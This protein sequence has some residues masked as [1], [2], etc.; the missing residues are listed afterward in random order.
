MAT[1]RHILTASI[2]AVVLSARVAHADVGFDMSGGPSVRWIRTMPT[3]S[4]SGVT[5]AAREVPEQQVAMG[6]SL[7]ALGGAFDM[8]FV[9]DDRWVVPGFGFG[10]YGAVGS[11]SAIV[12]SVDGSIARVRP[13]S[14]YAVELLLPGVGYRVKRRR[15]MFSASLR[16]GVSGVKVRG[17][18]AGGADEQPL[19]L[20]AWSPM[21]QAELEVCRR[22]DPSTRACLQVA[23]R[24]Y[25]FS[26]MNGAT[27]GL[28]IE[29]GK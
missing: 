27:F 10:A 15:F 9:V 18:V 4:S 7:V 26:I 5:T 28:R 6:D 19:P 14:T 21:L 8:G 23:P 22:L 29:W 16:T 11:Y 12:T 17:S 1:A 25:D 13:W 2:G 24:I 3:L 20:A